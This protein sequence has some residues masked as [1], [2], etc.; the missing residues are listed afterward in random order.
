MSGS[1]ERPSAVILL[2]E[3]LSAVPEDSWGPRDENALDLAANAFTDQDLEPLLDSIVGNSSGA[4][5]QAQRG[6]RERERQAAGDDPAK[7]ARAQRR[8]LG[9]H[10]LSLALVGSGEEN[11][12]V[13]EAL[14]NLG[15][16]SLTDYLNYAAELL[17]REEADRN[18]VLDPIRQSKPFQGISLGLRAMWP[19]AVERIRKAGPK[20]SLKLELQESLGQSG[21]EYGKDFAFGYSALLV[22]IAKATGTISTMQA[23][24]ESRATVGSNVS[25]RER[26]VNAPVQLVARTIAQRR[27]L[28]IPSDIHT[29]VEANNPVALGIEVPTAFD[30]ALRH[31]EVG[32]AE[33]KRR[34]LPVINQIREAVNGTP[35]GLGD[36]ADPEIYGTHVG[37]DTVAFSLGMAESPL[38]DILQSLELVRPDLIEKSI[39][40]GLEKAKALAELVRNDK[41]SLFAACEKLGIKAQHKN[42]PLEEKGIPLLDSLCERLSTTA[43]TMP[44]E[45]MPIK[46]ARRNAARASMCL[47]LSVFSELL[48]HIP[49]PQAPAA[50]EASAA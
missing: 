29:I 14:G 4:L 25:S 16:Y 35:A 17:D 27:G 47:Y 46:T 13:S 26:E 50:Q 40:L 42:T 11:A 20:K 36:I 21:R 5:L 3:G 23:A 49:N 44:G 18:V 2:T 15:T 45:T 37:A 10:T 8:I 34:E 33:L 28:A 30:R 6:F 31:S 43:L 48:Q 1:D 32:V 24:I 19:K 7:R 22:A 9:F 39:V 12:E 38:H 41:T